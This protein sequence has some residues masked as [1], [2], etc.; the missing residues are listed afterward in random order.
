MCKQTDGGTP[1]QGEQRMSAERQSVVENA[2]EKMGFDPAALRRVEQRIQQ[3]VDAQKYDG[4]R[5]VV[6]RRGVTVLDLAVGYADRA[7]N[8]KLASDSVFSVMSISKVMTT[9]A[10]LQC[11]E[12]GD[13]NLLTPVSRI[14]PE[15][16]ARGKERVTV[17][18]ILTHTAGLGMSQP[19]LS[20]EQLGVMEHSVKA[21]CDLPLESA[22][23]EQVSYSAMMGFTILGEIVHR[24]DAQGRAFRHILGQDVFEP[25][26]M[27]DTVLG[28]RASQAARRVPVIVRDSDAPELNRKFL[29]ARDEAVVESTELPS[30]GA[31]FSTG[32]DILRFGEAL[33][34][35]GALDGKR[36][37]SPAMVQFMLRNHTGTM[38]NSM[39]NSSRALHGM[40]A[41]PAFLGLGVFLRGEGIFPS[42][43]ASLA[44][45]ASFGGW[46]LGS[47]GFWVDPQRELTFVALTSG[48]M[49]RI[50]NLLR[51]QVLGDM[52]LSSLVEA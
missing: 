22:P 50:R 8:R 6:A 4:A 43:I 13:L 51:F 23:G 20:I 1:A 26:G 27:R 19:A 18:Q 3:D 25:L 33:R 7:A 24:L 49:E 17:G 36:V 48:V 21:I 34:Q 45:P 40:A 30:G 16:A 38:P 2:A 31:T 11:V 39:M 37:L 29:A 10:L 32:T 35:G 47:M 52:V 28:L 5:I 44:S 12:R 42:H 46:G 15:F 14:I 9:V 41:F